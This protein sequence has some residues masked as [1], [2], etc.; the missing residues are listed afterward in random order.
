MADS[1]SGQG[2]VM[3]VI[4]VLFIAIAIATLAVIDARIVVLECAANIKPSR[5]LTTTDENCPQPKDE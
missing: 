1:D 4:G 5:M 2:C 3:V